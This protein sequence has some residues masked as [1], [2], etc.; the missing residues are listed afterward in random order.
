MEGR[1][2]AG[3]G[4]PGVTETHGAA[5]GASVPPRP[6]AKGRS[7]PATERAPRRCTVAVLPTNSNPTGRFLCLFVFQLCFPSTLLKIFVLNQLY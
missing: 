2:S 5:V 3:G 1:S 6:G 4:N 7:V